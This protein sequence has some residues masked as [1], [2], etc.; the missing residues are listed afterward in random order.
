MVPEM[1]LGQ[2]I[3][4]IKR[5]L[6]DS[7]T[8]TPAEKRPKTAGGRSATLEE[9]D[10]LPSIRTG[11]ET[12]GDL[13]RS[14]E[15]AVRVMPNS[16]SSGIANR[17]KEFLLRYQDNPEGY[18][19]DFVISNLTGFVRRYPE[20]LSDVELNR[21][22]Q[23]AIEEKPDLLKQFLCVGQLIDSDNTCLDKRL[24][25]SII[26]R[27][28]NG[29]S[30]GKIYSILSDPIICEC[31]LIDKEELRKVLAPSLYQIINDMVYSDNIPALILDALLEYKPD[32]VREH[33]D[34]VRQ[35][36]SRESQLNLTDKDRDELEWRKT[37]L[38]AVYI[39]Q[40]QAIFADKRLVKPLKNTKEICTNSDLDGLWLEL[41]KL[42]RKEADLIH[43]ILL[44]I[45]NPEHLG[46]ALTQYHRRLTDE[47]WVM[48]VKKFPNEMLPVFMPW[49]NRMAICALVE[50]ACRLPDAVLNHP[51]ASRL[52]HLPSDALT[53]L[54]RTPAAAR[55]LLSTP[56]CMAVSEQPSFKAAL[57]SAVNDTEKANQMIDELL[58]ANVGDFSQGQWCCALGHLADM[59]EM[60]D[61]LLDSRLMKK[62]PFAVHISIL[63]VKRPGLLST[64]SG[65]KVKEILQYQNGEIVAQAALWIDVIPYEWVELIRKEVE[66]FNSRNLYLL[67]KYHPDILNAFQDVVVQ[68][69][70]CEELTKLA[71]SHL[72]FSYYLASQ[73]QWAVL[74]RVPHPEIQQLLV[75]ARVLMV[76][77]N[78]IPDEKEKQVLEYDN[79]S[80]EDFLKSQDFFIEHPEK[81]LST[82]KK[83][84]KVMNKILKCPDQCLDDRVLPFLF[85]NLDTIFLSGNQDDNFE[86]LLCCSNYYRVPND[87][88]C[89]LASL[90][91]HYAHQIIMDTR[92]C[93]KLTGNDY[94][95]IADHYPSLAP[96]ILEHFFISRNL[97]NLQIKSLVEKNS[98]LIPI[99]HENNFALDWQSLAM[100]S[101]DHYCEVSKLD[102]IEGS[103]ENL[104][105]LEIP[106]VKPSIP[107]RRAYRST[108][109]PLKQNIISLKARKRIKSE[110]GC[111]AGLS[112]D[113]QRFCRKHISNYSVIPS[114]YARKGEKTNGKQ[115][116]FVNRILHYQH[117][118][119]RYWQSILRRI[120]LDKTSK[121]LSELL[122]DNIGESGELGLHK[123][124]HCIIVVKRF[125][126][127]TTV[128]DFYIYDA[129][130]GIY[131]FDG[132]RDVK[133]LCILIN[134]WFS[135]VES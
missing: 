49:L 61:R 102:M 81:M 32:D 124:N 72:Q 17:A 60:T 34:R 89:K 122:R 67:V 90:R 35:L 85:D 50:L 69:C 71:V 106:I 108:L 80:F 15:R 7:V 44:F 59:P 12:F 87:Q 79:Y 83:H 128:N 30:R 78:S 99:A 57:Y 42:N 95:T 82:V 14:S 107:I 94:V 86:T 126:H 46:K 52:N 134:E 120:H 6:P 64:L 5:S 98:R 111:C 129:N 135:K 125:N 123:F 77:S 55:Y 121:S 54:L 104:P 40:H 10:S 127:I 84:P 43:H 2:P 62:L 21:I 47:H 105:P 119:K 118:Q 11:I 1:E 19:I 26:L 53:R 41:L 110:E 8:D 112:L 56:S 75:Q 3:V 31:A 9:S 74:H 28:V 133:Y 97:S 130:H 115:D 88:W 93:D 51:A 109:T 39:K 33:K 36:K 132:S 27:L 131:H 22:F 18:N 65:S 29:V 117:N 20:F 91:L 76:R 63:L 37:F 103:S 101:Y 114:D 66:G 16:Q 100:I 96:V 58:D 38:I 68:K 13:N 45:S 113:F 116:F 23:R 92:L 24:V 73:N 70:C 48:L 4:P 25:S